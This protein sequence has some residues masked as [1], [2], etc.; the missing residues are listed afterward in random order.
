M[1]IKAQGLRSSILTFP[2]S[3]IN[4]LKIKTKKALTTTC[5]AL[6]DTQASPHNPQ[7]NPSKET[8]LYPFS[9]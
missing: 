7:A 6:F 4:Q 1:L 5:G 3:V 2:R 9:R 8:G